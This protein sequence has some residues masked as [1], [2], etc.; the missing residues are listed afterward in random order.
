VNGLLYMRAQTVW[1][2]VNPS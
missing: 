1:S 2:V